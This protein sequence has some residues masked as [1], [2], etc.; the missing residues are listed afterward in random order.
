MAA[1]TPGRVPHVDRQRPALLWMEAMPGRPNSDGNFNSQRLTGAFMEEPVATAALI[2][3]PRRRDG[4]ATLALLSVANDVESLERLLMS[5]QEQAFARGCAR[6]LGP[7]ALSPH[8]SYGALLDHFNQ[9]PPLY[10]P[11]NAPYLPEVLEAVLE[12][13]Q[14]ARLYHISVSAG[15]EP[16]PGPAILRPLTV[17]EDAKVL[18]ALLAALDEPAEFPRPD[19]VEAAFLLSWWGIAPRLGWI[20]EV[21]AEPVGFVLL[22]PDLAPAMRRAK[23]GRNPL[24]QLWWQWRRTQPSRRGRIVAA[25]V[26]PRWRRKGIGSQLWTAALA[27]AHAQGWQS[28]S[29]GPVA[30]ESAAQAFLLAHGAQPL[31]HYA[32]YGT[33]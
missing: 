20:A 12:S 19:A 3:D 29:V 26:L 28:I 9:T 4:T 18:P 24:W 14:T 6:L 16:L 33:E 21:E 17:D 23:G 30:D 27:S 7:V 5:A 32:L 22:Q 11:Y 15:T 25:G 13:V 1:L 2:A 10:T 31:Q 8:L